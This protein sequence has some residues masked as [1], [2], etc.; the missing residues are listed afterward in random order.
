MVGR[1][2]KHFYAA[3]AHHKSA[4]S[5]SLR[6]KVVD[7]RNLHSRYDE[8]RKPH[9]QGT[10]NFSLY[11]AKNSMIVCVIAKALGF[12]IVI[13]LITSLLSCN[14]QKVKHFETLRFQLRPFL[15]IQ[16]Q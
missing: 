4:S 14:R 15:M 6:L 7:Y 10:R 2:T 9:H 5:K 12:A 13:T 1:V 3:A 16:M 8:L 11:D